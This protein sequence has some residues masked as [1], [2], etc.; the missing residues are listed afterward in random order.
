VCVGICARVI[1]GAAFPF[2][3]VVV[4]H[5]ANIQISAVDH[6]D[7]IIITRTVALPLEAGAVHVSL[8]L[9]QGW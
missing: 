9:R 6:N 5:Q 3:M 4:H 7:I 8:S 2:E 1:S